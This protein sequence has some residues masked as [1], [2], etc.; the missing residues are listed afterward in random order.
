MRSLKSYER[1]FDEEYGENFVNVLIADIVENMLP[2]NVLAA[3]FISTYL[4]YV[5]LSKM[6][7]KD[8]SLLQL[9]LKLERDVP[10]L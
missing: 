3:S 7:I 5:C 10:A 2:S 8:R 9:L 6:M 4:R 1:S